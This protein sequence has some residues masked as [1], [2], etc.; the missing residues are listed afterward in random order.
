[1]AL[2]SLF[3]LIIF[4]SRYYKEIT[5]RAIFLYLL[6]LCSIYTARWI[7]RKWLLKDKWMLF[8][9]FT[10][11]SIALFSTIGVIGFAYFMNFK[12]DGGD[13]ARF[14]FVFIPGLVILSIG[15]ASFLAITRIAVRQQLNEANV[16]RQQKERE[17]SLLLSQ[18]S[19][20]FL[21]NTLNNLYGLSIRQHETI[22]G[23]LLKLSD[24][25]RYSVYEAR[26]HSVL[27]KD[28][29]AYI[30][31]YIA[32][33]KIRLGQRLIINTHMEEII[34][35]VK[36]APM[37]FIVFVENAFKHARN[38]TD[39]KIRIDMD[40]SVEN[41][42]IYFSIRNSYSM[43]NMARMSSNKNSGLGI[44]ST[45]KRLQLLYPGEYLLERQKENDRYKVQLQ[46]KAW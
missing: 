20:H 31:N 29:V 22:P 28:E 21:F 24:L 7:S 27:L 45:I 39:E 5:P 26:Q 25:L 10:C 32:M 12:F 40:L 36:I 38:T 13:N 30:H 1:M 43:E 37:L 41:S 35:R 16:A 2:L 3:C 14:I 33:E 6:V 18:L 23:L 34:G 46:L 15:G 4:S 17:L 9:L 19:P 8:I 44:E 42:T 11:I